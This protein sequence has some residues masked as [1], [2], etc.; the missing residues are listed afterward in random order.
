MI[1]AEARLTGQTERY[2]NVYASPRLPGRMLQICVQG[3][4]REDGTWQ[5]SASF[6]TSDNAFFDSVV[7]VFQGWEQGK[8][9]ALRFARY[10]IDLG[11]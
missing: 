3:A 8:A 10:E 9:A 2:A 11:R 7:G 4:E 1:R 5:I 6:P